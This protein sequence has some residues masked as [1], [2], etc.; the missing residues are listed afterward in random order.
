MNLLARNNKIVPWYYFVGLSPEV[1]INRDSW[2]NSYF[3]VKDEILG[4]AQDELLRNHLPRM[5]SLI[6]NGSKMVIYHHSL[7]H[8]LCRLR[9]GSRF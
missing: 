7:N 1:I 6:K 5:F 9:I 2:E 3:A 8:K 4:L